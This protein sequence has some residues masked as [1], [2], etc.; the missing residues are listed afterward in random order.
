MNDDII[1]FFNESM[2][3]SNHLTKQLVSVSTGKNNE[4]MLKDTINAEESKMEPKM[5][6]TAAVDTPD[7]ELP[8]PMTNKHDMNK[9]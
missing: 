1:A 9:Q 2:R 4:S 5:Q 3:I 7:E 6:Q 8:T